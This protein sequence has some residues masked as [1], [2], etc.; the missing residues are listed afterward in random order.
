MI[1]QFFN[2]GTGCGEGTVD[3]L[4]GKDR[5]RE[6]AKLLRGHDQE[7]VALIN[8]LDFEKRYTSGCLSFEEYDIEPDV[9]RQLMDEFEETLF[10]GLDKNQ[11][12]VLWVEHRDKERL[13]LNF[14]IPNV[15]LTSGNRLQPYYVG[16]DY[17]RVD[18][19][20]Q[21]KNIEHGFADPDDPARS[22]STSLSKDLPVD[23]KAAVEMINQAVE[24]AVL[25]GVVKDRASVVDYLKESG[26]E[27]ARETQQSISIKDP[28]G[29]RNIRL[30][31]AIYERNF[32]FS[33]ALGTE[34]KARSG[35]YQSRVG[36]RLAVAQERYQ[37]GIE[38][39][40]EYLEQRYRRADH[41]IAVN[42]EEADREAIRG[43]QELSESSGELARSI[44][45]T[46]RDHGARE[47][48]ED[49]N[50]TSGKLDIYRDINLQDVDDPVGI[51]I[52]DSFRN[53][54]IRDVSGIS[55]QGDLS[56]DQSSAAVVSDI[57]RSDKWG[58]DQDVYG[59]ERGFAMRRTEPEL[60]GS[61]LERRED[62]GNTTNYQYEEVGNEYGNTAVIIECI[63][64]FNE[65]VSEAKQRADRERIDTDKRLRAIA[66]RSARA[67]RSLSEY[68][69]ELYR[70]LTESKSIGVSSQLFERTKQRIGRA[71]GAVSQFVE[72]VKERISVIKDQENH[73]SVEFVRRGRGRGGHQADFDLSR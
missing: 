4:L 67:K 54:R 27:I 40:R 18:A 73:S 21:I 20:K 48:E 45:K 24:R 13:E 70:E 36:E 23:K 71:I 17:H 39:R 60:Q 37:Y 63:N 29:G 66:E 25:T 59:R 52:D 56:G 6:Q 31:G 68:S 16:A 38:K 11:Y 15:E 62:R 44:V 55:A 47:R 42:L 41:A 3:Y 57:G 64:G 1:V 35:E 49:P 19:W 58:D 61:E 12:S 33:R 51:G 5:D 10:P 43:I 22:Q 53:D 14:V 65:R 69:E 30:K 7:T 46:D 2:R 9:K 50:G 32:E 72:K 26:I 34:I 28:E 8:G